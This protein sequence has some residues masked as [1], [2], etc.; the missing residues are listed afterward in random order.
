MDNLFYIIITVAYLLI[1][2]I[3][4]LFLRKQANKSMDDYGI[5]SNKFG[6]PVIALVSMGAWVGSAGLVGLSTSGYVDGVMGYWEYAMA[7]ICI[8]PWVF[9]FVPRIK[10]LNLYTIPDFFKLRY[11]KFDGF[12]QYPTGF[13]FL[14]RNATVLG[15][16]LNAL[17]FMFSSFFGWSHLFGVGISA[18]IIALYVS[19]SGLMSVMVTNFIQS[20]FQTAAPFIAFVFVIYAA[21]GWN[22]ITTYYANHDISKNLSLFNGT[23]WIGNLIYYIFTVG[24]FYA[25]S[26]QSDWQRVAAAKDTKTATKSMIIGA[27]LVVPLLIIPCYVGAGAR[28]VLGDNADPNLVFYDL[29]QIAGPIVGSLLIIGVMSTILSCCSSYLFAGGM[30]ISHDI[31]VPF[32]KHKGRVVDDKKEIFYSRIGIVLCCLTSILFAARIEGLISLWSAGLSIC[33]AGLVVPY[34]FAWFSKRGNTESAIASM[35]LA[36][37]TAF[38]WTMLGNPFGI[39]AIWI[40]LPISLLCCYIVPFFTERPT[41]E[42]I[43]QTYYYNEKFKKNTKNNKEVL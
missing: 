39:D 24:L 28:V 41:K 30:N 40:G 27:A 32:L 13:F 20:I 19:I 3:I 9:I 42:E 15:M 10:I 17:A 18:V 2:V 4:S 38:V 22:E 31:I 6:T 8:F 35:F 14:I 26:D 21:G 33:A 11:P 29:I 5:A 23:E 43:S 36:G 25:I 7:F 12:I 1:M 34:L 16:Q 37:G